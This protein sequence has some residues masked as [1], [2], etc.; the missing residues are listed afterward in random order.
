MT[1]FP[2]GVNHPHFT[3]SAPIN[4]HPA[5]YPVATNYQYFPIQ[6]PINPFHPP[7]QNPVPSPH[8]RPREKTAYES[9]Y[10]TLTIPP[11]KYIQE[12]DIYAEI[13][14]IICLEAAK[15]RY[16]PPPSNTENPQQRENKKS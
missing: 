9:I 16:S 8:K 6:A 5:C 2:G 14:A 10:E 1:P 12:D 13:Q 4:G 3:L 7:K 15:T 11:E